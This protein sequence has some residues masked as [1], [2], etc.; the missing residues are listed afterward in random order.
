VVILPQPEQK[1][2]PFG[3]LFCWLDIRACRR[4]FAACWQQRR[5][6]RTALNN[7]VLGETTLDKEIESGKV[8]V[9][10][11]REYLSELVALLDKF[12]F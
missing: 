5:M 6:P 2:H 12:D 1:S 9:E 8:M 10:G 4:Q 7:I 3:W 11:K